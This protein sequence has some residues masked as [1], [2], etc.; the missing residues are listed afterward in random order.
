MEFL[1][2][3]III[4]VLLTILG[5]SGEMMVLG[6]MALIAVG[7]GLM[8]VLFLYMCIR[9]VLAKKCR[10]R[11]LRIDQA[12]KGKYKVAYYQVDGQEYPCVFPSEMI[13]NDKMYRPERDY[14]I[15]ISRRMGKVFDIWTI[16]TC[17][18]GLVCSAMMCG[19]VI[20]IIILISG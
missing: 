11:F 2:A 16:L 18:L 10:G 20:Y 5:V 6:G 13:L 17:V 12:P 7:I 14:S 4:I 8:A 3:L 19:G 15:R 9:L 1:L